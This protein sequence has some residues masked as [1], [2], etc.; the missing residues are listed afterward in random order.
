[1]LK[2]VPIG[3][4]HIVPIREHIEIPDEDDINLEVSEE[5]G[6]DINDLNLY[7]FRDIHKSIH[8][9]SSPFRSKG[10]IRVP[11]LNIVKLEEQED[12]NKVE[13]FPYL[14]ISYINGERIRIISHQE[15]SATNVQLTLGTAPNCN[16]RLESDNLVVMEWEILFNEGKFYMRCLSGDTLTL[17]KVGETRVKLRKHNYFTLGG[18]ASFVIHE[19]LE[20]EGSGYLINDNVFD[21]R[22]T[23]PCLYSEIPQIRILEQREEGSDI[24]IMGGG[25]EREYVFGVS[26]MADHQLPSQMGTSNKHFRIGYSR[27]FGWYIIDGVSGKPS[28]NGTYL[29]IQNYPISTI[30]HNPHPFLLHGIMQ[31]QIGD[32]TILVFIYDIYSYY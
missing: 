3:G 24:T 31:F 17:Y 7:N 4:G 19:L 2:E 23:A 27:G 32:L 15:A 25:E 22:P 9:N 16:I 12:D 26:G 8:S 14:V 6:K 30:L 1:M 11:K 5:Y 10:K 18:H 21:P 13:K 28:T 20:E 29:A